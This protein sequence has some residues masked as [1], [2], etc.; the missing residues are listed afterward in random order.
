ME[1]TMNSLIKKFDESKLKNGLM[2]IDMPTG[3]GKTYTAIK[4][5]YE[6][7]MNEKNKDRKYMSL[8]K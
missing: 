5:I 4:Y 1:N 2:L 3:S 6:A 8:S 7:C